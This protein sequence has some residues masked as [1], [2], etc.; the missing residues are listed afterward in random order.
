LT[1]MGY[2]QYF[3]NLT[4]LNNDAHDFIE[5]SGASEKSH[6]LS[7]DGTESEPSR[8]RDGFSIERW[9]EGLHRGKKP[10][11][12]PKPRPFQFDVE[13][14]TFDDKVYKL[15]DLT[16]HNMLKLA[17]RIGQFSTK[18]HTSADDLEEVGLRLEAYPESVNDVDDVDND[19]NDDSGDELEFEDESKDGEKGNGKKGKGKKQQNKVWLHFL[20]HAFV[21]TVSEKDLKKI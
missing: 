5:N 18:A 1:L 4:Y 7:N 12:E 10:G 21:S 2:T 11:H 6:E 17:Y 19:T 20:R 9:N 14:S 3:A 8:E 15:K 13:Y 16:V